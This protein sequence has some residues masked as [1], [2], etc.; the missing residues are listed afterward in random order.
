MSPIGEIRDR[1]LVLAPEVTL[2]GVVEYTWTTKN[3]SILAHLDFS[4]QGDHNFDIQNHPATVEEGYTIA[5]ARVS[6][7]SASEKYELVVFGKNIFDEEYRTY[8]FNLTDFFGS[9]QQASGRES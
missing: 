6:Y 1:D 8:V 7:I 2:N 3:G 5:N 9:L 4:H